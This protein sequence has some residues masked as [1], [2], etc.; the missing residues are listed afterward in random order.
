MHV[1]AY[2]IA[3][4]IV[5]VWTVSIHDAAYFTSHPL[6]NGA[7]HHTV[8]HLEFNYNYGQYT[9]I[10]DRIGGSYRKPIEQFENE[11]FFERNQKAKSW[12]KKEGKGQAV[13][14][15]E[16]LDGSNKATRG[17]AKRHGIAK[18]E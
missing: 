1:A 13:E 3:F 7:A 15:E 6:I 16:E 17:L 11:M 10:W 2:L 12:E 5:Q 8:H 18:A 14:E 9:T 4:I